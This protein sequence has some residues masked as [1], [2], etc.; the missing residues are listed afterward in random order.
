MFFCGFCVCLI[1]EWF[2]FFLLVLGFLYGY[3]ENGWYVCIVLVIRKVGLFEVGVIK[4]I[5][6][7]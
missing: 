7:I 6:G 5:L 1:G 3:S 2:G 4:L